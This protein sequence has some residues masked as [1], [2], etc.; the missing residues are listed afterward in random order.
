MLFAEPTAR[1]LEPAG[2]VVHVDRLTHLWNRR[3]IVLNVSI[4]PFGPDL[5]LDTF[6]LFVACTNSVHGLLVLDCESFLLLGSAKGRK[7]GVQT[8]D[9][10]L[11]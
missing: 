3:N 11:Y 8:N 6:G 10:H 2:G 4:D 5:F 1:S 7:L 9:V